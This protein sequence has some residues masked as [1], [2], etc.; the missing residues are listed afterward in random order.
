MISLSIF[1]YKSY[2]LSCLLSRD[3][4]CDRCGVLLPCFG[5]LGATGEVGW[6]FGVIILAYNWSY[7]RLVWGRGF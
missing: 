6:L 3:W 4:V 2:E 1:T 5:A 7:E